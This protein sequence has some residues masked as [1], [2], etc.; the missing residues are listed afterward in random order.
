[1]AFWQRLMWGKQEK[2][3]STSLDLF[4]E[5]HGGREVRSGQVVNW[6]T[7]IDVA[8]VLAC[9]RVIAEGCSQIPWRVF[10]DI[11]DGGRAPAPG[12]YLYRLIYRRPNRWQT[13]FEF[14]ETLLFHTVLTGNAFCLKLRTGI[15]GEIRELIPIEPGRVIVERN[16]GED[17]PRYFIRGDN[18][19]K[20]EFPAALIWH[21]RGPS[22]NSWLG[23]DAVYLAREAIGL[24]MATEQAHADFHKGGAKVSGLLS[25]D[26]TL[27]PERYAFLAAWIDKYVIGGERSSKPMIMDNG[28]KFSPMQMT[29]VDA[30]HIETRKHQIEEICRAFRVMPIMVGH[31]DKTATYASAEQMFL[32]HVIHTLAPWYERIEQSADANLLS[33][34]DRAQGFYTKFTP[35]AL[36]RGAAKDRSEFYAKALGSG[37]AK[38]WMTQNEV[39]A[40]EE[41]DRSDDPEADIL[42]QP[43]AAA[44][45]PP[46]D[47]NGI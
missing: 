18:G 10:R 43:P 42:P 33:D 45:P 35:N 23:L 24:A 2:D 30:Q 28:G 3:I 31:A 47:N 39:R 32:A 29:G 26:G 5:I 20:K 11:G 7:A 15:A 22:W 12:H 34:D 37:G 41:L 16:P 38:G 27:T 14:R 19:E 25:V 4:R 13:S 6:K 44:A 36:M 46:A 21:I 1:M 17:V 8:T 40:F 9:T